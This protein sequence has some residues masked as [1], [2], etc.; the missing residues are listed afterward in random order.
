MIHLK[1]VSLNFGPRIIADHIH[2]IIERGQ[3]AALVGVNGT[4]KSSLFKIISKTIEPDD[5]EVI[6]QSGIKVTSLA[7]DI[8]SNINGSTIQVVQNASTHGEIWQRKNQAEK[9]LMEMNLDPDALFENLSGGLK[10]RVLLACA[11]IDEPDLLLLDEPSNHLDLPS[12]SW[13]ERF[14]KKQ[15]FAF[16]VISHDR[17]LLNTISQSIIELDRG[18]I[19]R[20][21]CGFNEYVTQKQELLEIEKTEQALF[22]KRLEDEEAWI[23]KGVKARGTRNEGRVR[24][25]KAMRNEAA[26]RQKRSKGAFFQAQSAP[27][28]GKKIIDARHL[29]Y[30]FENQKIVDDFSTKIHRGDKIGVIGPNG[31]G[32]TTLVRLLLGKLELQQ[33]SIKYGTELKTAYFDQLRNQLNPEKSV[34]DNVA[35]GSDLIVINGQERHVIGYLKGFLFS[36]EKSNALVKTLSGGE[37]NRLMLAKLFTIAANFLILDEPSNDL[38]LETIEVLEQTLKDY[39]GTLIVIS[40]DR[41]LLNHVVKRMIVMEK[42]G[43][44]EEYVGAYDDYMRQRKTPQTPSSNK[45]ANKTKTEEE[46][47]QSKKSAKAGLSFVEQHELEAIPDQITQLEQQQEQ[48]HQAMAKADFFKQDQQTILKTQ[49]ELEHIDQNLEAKLARWEALEEKAKHHD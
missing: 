10:R 18:H 33:G 1:D 42:D 35:D 34:R 39:Q 20:F 37:R 2:M 22:D 32:K 8:P 46:K 12:I 19:R 27:L 48:L 17:H 6:Y 38:D 30:Q 4:G 23:R 43:Q 3:H 9:L 5:G 13:L 47:T 26:A 16:L 14:L 36:Q 28:S 24:A 15:S 44:V 29:S 11:I 40:H 21:E 31:S 49:Q 7:Q 45:K 41:E 25:L